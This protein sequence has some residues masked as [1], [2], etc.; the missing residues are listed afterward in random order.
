MVCCSCCCG[1]PG[2]KDGIGG[3]S[4]GSANRSRSISSS[5]LRRIAEAI[6]SSRV[7][8]VSAF[9]SLLFAFSFLLLFFSVAKVSVPSATLL[10]PALSELRR[11]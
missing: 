5:Q 9:F 11:E 8:V 2:G 4:G 7:L 3:C 10:L 6:S 1:G